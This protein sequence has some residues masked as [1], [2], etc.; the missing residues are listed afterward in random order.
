MTS[1]A[2]VVCFV[3][4]HTG[5]ADHFAVFAEELEK[6]GYQVRIYASGPALKKFEERSIG[7][8]PFDLDKTSENEAVAYIAKRCARASVVITDVGHAFQAVLHKSLA[9][10]APS[11]LRL[12]YY[13]NPEPYV[14]GNYSE[15]A[16]KVMRAA[17]RVLFANANLAGEPIYEAPGKA[18][19][20]DNRKRFGVGYY[21]L[22]QAEKIALRRQS[23]HLTLRSQIFHQCGLE[24]SGQ[25]LLVYAGGNNEEYFSKAFPAFLRFLSLAS[26]TA[27]LSNYV[28]LLQQHPGAA[29][30]N[31]DGQLLANWLTQNQ[32]K[33]L[34][35]FCVSRT[36]FEN[37][38]VAADV[39]LYYQT[40]MGPQFVLAGIPVI[41]TGHNCYEDVLIK[42]H[43]CPS[44]VN[45]NE[46]LACL[47][48]LRRDGTVS[49][50]MIAQ[51][52][53][54]HL[55]WP[56]RLDQSIRH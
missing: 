21:P 8:E 39:I 27:D 36:T 25:T 48:N 34:P 45:E 5:P 29:K 18:V 23:E 9:E 33:S 24:E 30:L 10:E 31:R 22:S 6:K 1:L 16:A 26:Q 50:E 40:S 41:Q 42:N 35:R 4:C 13:D 47:Q 37:A 11:V 7:V 52:L 3:S 46:L 53:G 51:A 28:V 15:T 14:P 54:F 44:A 56:E 12:A 55:D 20:L 17:D 43:L 38:E 2:A 49:R 32:G 19:E